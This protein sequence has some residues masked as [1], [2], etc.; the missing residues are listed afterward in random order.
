MSESGLWTRIGTWLRTSRS[1]SMTGRP[2]ESSALAPAA[3]LSG[4]EA[5]RD[6]G[7]DGLMSR[8]SKRDQTFQ[9]LQE[10]FERLADVLDGVRSH[11]D[12]HAERSRAMNASLQ[13]LVELTRQLP[14]RSAEQSATLERI[15]GAI[16]K[17]AERDERLASSLADLPALQRRQI[18]TAT[19][20]DNQLQAARQ[21][22]EALSAA[23]ERV[24]GAVNRWSHSVD[25]QNASARAVQAAIERND[26]AVRAMM[27]RQ[28]RTWT[29]LLVMVLVVATA[30]LAVG[31]VS[32][33]I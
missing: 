12:E 4:D 11:L 7:G 30:A 16:A 15:A 31:V 5:G 23:V 17:S 24:G 26:E 29:W 18:E 6:A 13:Q 10:G 27:V 21:S 14:Q 25:E 2:A 9:K 20:I 3:H 32:L 33:A 28:H 1:R 22:D 19:A 8:W